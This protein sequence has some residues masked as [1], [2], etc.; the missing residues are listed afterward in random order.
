[1]RTRREQEDC[2]RW[3]TD[4]VYA[5]FVTSCL[6]EHTLSGDLWRV[7][8]LH[9]GMSP[10]FPLS[11]CPGK[12]ARHFS[13][14]WQ[15]SCASTEHITRACKKH[16]TKIKAIRWNCS[17]DARG[18]ND[19]FVCCP[20]HSPVLVQISIVFINM[21]S[22]VSLF[23][24]LPLISIMNRAAQY[25]N[26]KRSQALESNGNGWGCACC[27][28][29]RWFHAPPIVVPCRL[30][31]EKSQCR[32]KLDWEKGIWLWTWV[33]GPPRYRHVRFKNSVPVAAA[34]QKTFESSEE[35]E[36]GTT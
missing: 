32:L 15:L 21:S 6:V 34:P 19:G 9:D 13:G 16:R 29:P 27:A 4:S 11:D 12:L 18:S 22:K 8:G 25:F 5:K 35:V 2:G 17:E 24:I 33:S 31:F 3:E 28:N 23:R 26:Q 36:W 1:M 14:L 30:R 20:T 7:F 10:R